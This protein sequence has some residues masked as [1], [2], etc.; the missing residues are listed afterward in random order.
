M[1]K[2]IGTIT[3]I[4]QAGAIILADI[5]VYGQP[6]SAML[7]DSNEQR[8]W[9]KAG[10]T[11]TVVFKETE[12]SIG[13]GLSGKISL[14]NRFLCHIVSIRKGELLSEIHLK[15]GLYNLTSVITTRSVESLELKEGEEVEALVKANEVS[16]MK[17]I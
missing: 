15:F 9:L 2:L 3:N 6:V 16:L 13:K 7:I 12:V 17:P 1:N 14:R 4:Q 11:V 10:N 8:E 5:E